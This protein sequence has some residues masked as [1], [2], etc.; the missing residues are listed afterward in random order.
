MTTVYEETKRRNDETER[1]GRMIVLLEKLGLSC[2]GD[3]AALQAVRDR[4]FASAD[5]SGHGQHLLPGQ[6]LDLR[7]DTKRLRHQARHFDQRADELA[8]VLLRQNV[9]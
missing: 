1:I 9:S 8:L 7:L 3:F 2:I 4:C 5:R 6:R